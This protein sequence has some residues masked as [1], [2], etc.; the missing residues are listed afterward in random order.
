[1]GLCRTPTMK[2]KINTLLRCFSSADPVVTKLVVDVRV[3]GTT[4]VLVSADNR[5]VLLV[6]P[7]VL[8]HTGHYW[9]PLGDLPRLPVV[10]APPPPLLASTTMFAVL[11]LTTLASLVSGLTREDGK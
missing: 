6:G 4:A 11:C 3:A 8:R 7:P 9:F 5:Q 1:M 10:A 2:T